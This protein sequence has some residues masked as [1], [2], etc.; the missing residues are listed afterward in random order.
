MTTT[1][2]ELLD[3]LAVSLFG[4]AKATTL[5]D[6]AREE[7]LAQTVYPFVS[8]DETAM[9]FITN[10]LR[11][12]WQQ[13]EL[14]ETMRD[15]GIPFV[16]LKGLAAAMYYPEPVTRTLGDVDI[17]VAPQDF[18]N[19]C[20]VLLAAGYTTTDPLEGEARHVHFYKND[21]LVELHRRYAL[22]NS[23]TAIDLL[24]SWIFEAIP[25]AVIATVDEWNFP[26]LPEPLN[27][28]TLLA[29]ISQHLEEGLG[30]RQLVDW[31]IYV[32]RELPD[33]NWL[34]FQNLTDQLGL[35]RLAKIAARF[36]QLYLG[37]P[38][39]NHRW[40]MDVDEALCEA[41]AEY[42]FECGNFGQKAGT[43]NTVAMV[44]SHGHGVKGFF[45]NLQHRGE[46]NW[47]AYQKHHVLKP[48]CW[49]YQAL[50]YARFGLRRDNA[51]VNLKKDY[52]SGKKRND[53]MKAL[54]ATRLVER[55]EKGK[56]N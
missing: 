8:E 49:I 11:V 9:Q 41:M 16:V 22:L 34:E 14:T 18:A 53:L 6:E 39:Q 46:A 5:S 25:Q 36:G 17:I 7:A 43:S 30:L 12:A 10:N 13:Q 33:E 35:T 19:T 21:V 29:H 4:D 47:K 2:K 24:D 44:L 56:K 55:E 1:Q 54:G 42:A 45:R 48:F 32:S 31:V 50:R 23:Q 3:A 38:E 15:G 20:S 26:I 51:L 27:G 37:L 40:C 52:A 28:L